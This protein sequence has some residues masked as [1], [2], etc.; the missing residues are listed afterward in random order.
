MMGRMSAMATMERWTLSEKPQMRMPW[1]ELRWLPD[2]SDGNH[3]EVDPVRKATDED[4]LVRAAMVA[5]F[6]PNIAV[7][8]NGQRSPYWYIDSN[9]EVSPF[10]GSANAEYQMSGQDGD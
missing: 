9:E 6:M 3:G 4:A 10:R 1:S 7:L 8:Y 2:V 5:G